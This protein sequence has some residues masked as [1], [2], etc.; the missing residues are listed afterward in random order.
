MRQLLASVAF[1]AAAALLLTAAQGGD[2]TE[3][4]KEVTLKG[5][6]TCAKCDL[7]VETK[8]TTVIVVKEDKKDVIYYLDAKSGKENHKAICTAA[9]AGAVTGVVSTKD[10]KK[11]ITATKVVFDKE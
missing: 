11:T 8:C 7:G 9:K 10:D 1:V 2:K 5:K 3:K 4:A 6:I